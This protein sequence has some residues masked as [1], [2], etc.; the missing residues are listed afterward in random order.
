MKQRTFYVLTVKIPYAP[1]SESGNKLLEI[2]TIIKATSKQ[3][4]RKSPGQNQIVFLL[5]PIR[6][7]LAFSC[8]KVRRLYNA[9]GL[10]DPA[11]VIWNT[12]PVYVRQTGAKMSLPRRPGLNRRYDGEKYLR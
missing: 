4:H 5:W 12:F 10:S 11:S 3:R 2:N 9:R 6:H 1:T 7:K 8:I